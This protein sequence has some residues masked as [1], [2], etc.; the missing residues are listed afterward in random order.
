MSLNYDKNL[1]YFFIHELKIRAFMI[2]LKGRTKLIY[3]EKSSI[4]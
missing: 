2:K 1:A 4:I 3:S